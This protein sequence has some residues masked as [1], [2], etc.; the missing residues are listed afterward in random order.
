MRYEIGIYVKSAQILWVNGLFKC[1]THPENKIF[2]IDMKKH[3]ESEE[4][5]VANGE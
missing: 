5:V 4:S 1:G 3:L 2:T